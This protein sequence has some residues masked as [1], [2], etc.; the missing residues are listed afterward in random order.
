MVYNTQK[1]WVS[2]RYIFQIYAR[3]RNW[4]FIGVIFLLVHN[5][6]RPLWAIFRW[7]TITLLTRI[8]GAA[9]SLPFSYGNCHMKKV[10]S[11]PHSVY[12]EEAIDII[13]DPL[14]HNLSLIIYLYNGKW[15]Y[16]ILK[17]I[18]YNFLK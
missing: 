5:M 7:N 14:F 18:C 6:F 13:T 4:E 16:Y 3:D 9:S 1:K 15:A 11:L 2:G 17:W 10:A 12:L 8:Q